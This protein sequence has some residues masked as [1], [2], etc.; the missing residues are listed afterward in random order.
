MRIELENQELDVLRRVVE[1]RLD[2][3]LGQLSAADSLGF[4]QSLKVEHD[5]LAQVY[6]KL[7][8]ERPERSTVRSCAVDA[9][10]TSD[11]EQLRPEEVG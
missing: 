10:D 11:L 5:V 8:C 3:L 4:K 2:G 6:D 1:Q 9:G 7:G